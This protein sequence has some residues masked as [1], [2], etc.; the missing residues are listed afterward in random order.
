[1][2]IDSPELVRRDRG[3]NIDDTF[4]ARTSSASK[5]PGAVGPIVWNLSKQLFS[6]EGIISLFLAQFIFMTII[7]ECFISDVNISVTSI[8]NE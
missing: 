8:T 4:L 3:G 2:D 5:D 6:T 1:M 7:Y